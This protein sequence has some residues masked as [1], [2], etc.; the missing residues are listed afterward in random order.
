M[1]VQEE[2]QTEASKISALDPWIMFETHPFQKDA[3]KLETI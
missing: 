3:D 1:I 2:W